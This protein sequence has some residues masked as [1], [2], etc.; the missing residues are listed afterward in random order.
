MDKKTSSLRRFMQTHWKPLAAFGGVFII[1]ACTLAWRLNT[2]LPGYSANEIQAFQYSQDLQYIWN[3]PLNAPYHLLTYAFSFLTDGPIATRLASITIAWFTIIIFCA[4]MYRW[5][6]TR[7]ALI[8]TLLLGTS[9][10]F[11]HV[12]RLGTP[13]A[14]FLAIVAL[15][16]LGVWIRERK[17]GLA[18]I[19]GL[20]L[21]TLLLYTPGMV[22][23]VAIGLL[24]QWKHIDTAFKKHL[25]SVTLGGILFLAGAAPLAFRLYQTPELIR[26]WLAIPQSWQAPGYYLQNFAEVPMA[27]FIRGQ[28]NPEMWLGRLPL[29]SVFEAAAFIAGTY[30]FYKHFKLARVKLFL[31][32]CVL[33]SIVIAISGN[34]VPLTVLVPFIYMVAAVGASYLID[35]WLK[36]FPRNPIARSMGIS[37]FCVVFLIANI[38]NLRSYFVAWPQAS[39]TRQHFT[40]K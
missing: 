7:T 10:W 26:S 28:E 2:L 39:T 37:L 3:N 25:G 13:Q 17:G 31:A 15:V 20:I 36:V 35:I 29:L 11:L 18:V 8:G 23:F 1:I 32:L 14:V 4:L 16:G 34:T 9:S 12:G 30:I 27:I 33:G 40:Y 38:Y 19:L 22:W 6:G 24:W 5:F 21:A